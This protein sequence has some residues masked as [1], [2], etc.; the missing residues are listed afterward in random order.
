M[1]KIAKH[2]TVTKICIWWKRNENETK[3]HE[4]AHFVLHSIL[5]FCIKREK[6]KKGGGFLINIKKGLNNIVHGRLNMRKT[7]QR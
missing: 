6:E 5:C 3:C 2:K 4:M 1:C 7:G